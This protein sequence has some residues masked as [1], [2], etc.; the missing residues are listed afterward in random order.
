MSERENEDVSRTLNL[1]NEAKAGDKAAL[2]ELL[3]RYADRVRQIV[4]IQ[5]GPRLRAS[6]D[7]ADL[8]QETLL[9]ACRSLDDFEPRSGESKFV[10]WL[11]KIAHRRVLKQA[12]W[13]TAQK[14]DVRRN[15]PI[16]EVAG[17]P[18]DSM[19]F[20]IQD[21]N[22]S[23]RTVVLENEERDAVVDC[24]SELPEHYRNVITMRHYVGSDWE[25]VARATGHPS[26]NAARMT[27]MRA[28]MALGELLRQRGI[29][30]EE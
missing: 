25:Q 30:A 5:L 12:A 10:Y 21:P 14:R 27:Y 4:R 20:D 23:P 9:E 3:D 29:T 1:V 15:T 18:G 28:R 6:A 11:A 16:A 24:V 7:S 19:E 8:M 22:C 13:Q 2:N 17:G 26:A